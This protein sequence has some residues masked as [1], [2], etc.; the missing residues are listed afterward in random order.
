MGPYLSVPST[1]LGVGSKYIFQLSVQEQ[2]GPKGSARVRLQA[3]DIFSSRAKCL[4]TVST[5]EMS[6]GEKE[7]GSLQI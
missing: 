3:I 2:G 5:A 6:V 7:S 1:C 4:P